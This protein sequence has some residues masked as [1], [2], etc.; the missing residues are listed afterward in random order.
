M[1]KSTLSKIYLLL[2]I[3]ILSCN[4]ASASYKFDFDDDSLLHYFDMNPSSE[5]LANSTITTGNKGSLSGIWNWTSVVMNPYNLNL[6]SALYVNNSFSAMHLDTASKYQSLNSP[7]LE[8]TESLNPSGYFLN[9][10]M[11]FSVWF[12]KNNASLAKWEDVFRFHSNN[13]VQDLRFQSIDSLGMKIRDAGGTEYTFIELDSTG[14]HQDWGWHHM[15]MVFRDQGTSLA[16]DIIYDN[17]SIKSDVLSD[18]DNMV[19]KTCTPNDVNACDIGHTD[20]PNLDTFNGSISEFRLYNIGLSTEECGA[21]HDV[22]LRSGN[23]YQYPFFT[24]KPMTV[25][26]TTIQLNYTSTDAISFSY[27]A[28]QY[29]T[30]TNPSTGVLQVNLTNTSLSVVYALI[31]ITNSNGSDTV[32]LRM[33]ATNAT[34][35]SVP[36][37]NSLVFYSDFQDNASLF[38]DVSV[39]NLAGGLWNYNAF[40]FDAVDIMQSINVN[41]TYQ[42]LNFSE[43]KST[44]LR[45]NTTFNPSTVFTTNEISVSMWLNASSLASGDFEILFYIV[46]NLPAIVLQKQANNTWQLQ[47]RTTTGTEVFHTYAGV[48][49][50]T[51]DWQHLGF[52]IKNNSADSYTVTLYHNGTAVSNQTGTYTGSFFGDDCD[53]TDGGCG[54]SEYLPTG[55]F[56]Y[57]G[58]MDEIRVYSHAISASEM[59]NLGNLSYLAGNQSANLSLSFDEQLQ[60]ATYVGGTSNPIVINYTSDVGAPSFFINESGISYLQDNASQRINLTFA[61]SNSRRAYYLRLQLNG[62]GLTDEQ[63]VTYLV[64]QYPTWD[65]QPSNISLLLDQ[66]LSAQFNWS[67]T[68]DAFVTTNNARSTVTTDNI[69][70]QANITFNGNESGVAT[71]AYTVSNG[72][73]SSIIYVTYNTTI[74]PRFAQNPTNVTYQKNTQNT[75]T[76]NYSS[77][78]HLKTVNLNDSLFNVSF[79]NSTQQINLSFNVSTQTTKYL[80]LNISNDDGYDDVYFAYIFA[81]N[82]PSAPGAFSEPLCAQRIEDS[83]EVVWGSASDIDGQSL[84]YTLE[85]S[86]NSGG[87]YSVFG[88]VSGLARNFTQTEL[89]GSSDNTRF[90]VR[91]YD[92]VEYGAYTDMGCD[93]ILISGLVG[94]ASGGSGGPSIIQQSILGDGNLTFEQFNIKPDTTLYIDYP[95]VSTT[96][97]NLRLQGARISKIS[98]SGSFVVIAPK[99]EGTTYNPGDDIA[100]DVLTFKKHY[101]EDPQSLNAKLKRKDGSTILGSVPLIKEKD[102]KYKL[103][104]KTENLEDGFYLIEILMTNS[105]TVSVEY[106]FN[107]RSGVTAPLYDAE[108]NLNSWI[109]LLIVG[110]VILILLLLRL[111]K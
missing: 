60:N 40:N 94:T 110:I 111:S 102:G 44:S 107:V 104:I 29:I 96:L 33:N 92:G 52:T 34:I 62:S 77:S 83:Y 18:I 57:K 42:A 98:D 103:L 26:S 87:T 89:G 86:F 55:T 8:V 71:V 90:R 12:R 22:R 16:Y 54:F 17:T 79:T 20:H 70:Q 5:Y 41:G 56:E 32:L 81:N 80:Y 73:G 19:I 10:S 82:P 6:A 65:Q 30:V 58:M 27:N 109:I 63:Y 38:N 61:P 4:V 31:N 25:T 51:G 88:N 75:V 47:V 2:A 15:C 21:L 23:T 108:G 95:K 14:H 59:H 66:V 36:E 39:L 69:T 35:P 49:Y 68:Y 106:G 101:A 24:R 45:V 76:I 3:I 37:S 64:D 13:E 43:A 100:F 72:N 11:T 105:P 78:Y 7:G 91:A 97:N 1:G 9:D 99:Q 53:A 67:A 48:N 46:D 50:I 93:F 84:I 74:N 85:Y 28:S